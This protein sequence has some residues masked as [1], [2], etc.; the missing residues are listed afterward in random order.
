VENPQPQI[1]ALS[2]SSAEVGEA[3]LMLTV[4]G[5]GFVAQSSVRWNG[6]PRPTT[7]LSSTEVTALLSASDLGSAGQAEM[8]VLNPAPGGGTS[9]AATFAL[10]RVV[11][12]VEVGRAY[13]STFVGDTTLLRAA[14][15][16]PQGDTLG[17]RPIQWASEDPA[18]ASVTPNGVVHGVAP[19]QVRITAS[20]SG[21]T[22]AVEVAI[23]ARTHRT[24]RELAYQR[25]SGS[26]SRFEL[27]VMRPGEAQ[28]T[29][30][31]APGEH[32]SDFA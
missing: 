15:I 21:A 23:L 32:V 4:Q 2:P 25:S 3:E 8:T 5:T 22:G 6:A 10:R 19:G 18:V 9:N 24:N 20:S 7:F 26:P 16:G 28:S 1:H 11:D 13:P 14:V 17:N 30:I 12:R 29:T 27:Q 31:S